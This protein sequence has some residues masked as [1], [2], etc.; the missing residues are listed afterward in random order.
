MAKL[1]PSLNNQVDQKFGLGD[2]ILHPKNGVLTPALYF[3]MD[4][5]P[6]YLNFPNQLA[7]IHKFEY[8]PIT[9]YQT[10]KFEQQPYIDWSDSI[11]SMD[12]EDR[13]SFQS[14]EIVVLKTGIRIVLAVMQV[15]YYID[16][17]T[18]IA[19]NALHPHF[20]GIAPKWKLA[21]PLMFDD[22]KIG[23]QILAQS[24]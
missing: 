12:L 15:L 16:P 10:L 5:S 2:I 1:V 8:E 3:K 6:L 17:V 9:E 7:N 14:G 4:T 21:L 24:A 20:V 22:V 18:G 11:H 23:E 19:Y 13:R